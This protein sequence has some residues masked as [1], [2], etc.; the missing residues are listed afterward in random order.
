MSMSVVLRE[1]LIR[2]VFA[3]EGVDTTHERAQVIAHNDDHGTGES[4][5]NSTIGRT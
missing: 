4:A 3:A 1:N 2:K 5:M